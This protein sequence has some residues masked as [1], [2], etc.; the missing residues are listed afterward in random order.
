VTAPNAGAPTAARG[1][2]RTGVDLL[3]YADRLGGTVADLAALLAGPLDAFTGVH[4]LP[5]FVPYDGADAGFD[6]VDH[7]T[8]DPRLGTWD[9]VAALARHR[10]LTADLIVNHVSSG[11]EPFR[12]WVAHGDAS[13]H[14]GM[15]LTYGTVFPGGATEA[16][17]SAIYRPRPGLPFTPTMVGATRRLLW[18]TFDRTQIDLDVHHPA[19]RRH[20]REVLGLLAAAGARTVRLDAVGY[21]VKTAGTDCFLT[22]ETMA[23]VDDLTAEARSLGLEV[24]VELHGHHRLQQAVAPHVDHV[25]DFGLPPLVLHALLTGRTHGLARWFDVRPTNTVNVLDTHDGIG[26]I[27]V[28]AEGPHAGIL[29][30]EDLTELVAAVEANTR[31]VSA[32]AS[33]PVPWAPYPYQL[34][35]TYYDALDRD[36]DRYVAARAIQLLTPG[37]P[38]VYYAGLLA[39]GNDTE[40]LARTGVGREVNRPVV[41][42]GDLGRHLDRPV[43]RALLALVRLRGAHPAFGGGQTTA[44]TADEVALTWRSG[45]H[46]AGVRIAPAEGTFELRWTTAAGVRRA[47]DTDSLA[48]AV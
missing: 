28:A 22:P 39:L 44:I 10:D 34:N 41:A 38:Q 29:A 9:D 2:R 12:D 32:R 43:V 33:R 45:P 21:A 46:E 25:Y 19:A 1:P 20:L 11:S 17:L 5:F 27:D 23:F 40:R 6:P 30:D 48:D 7:T 16:D 13:A 47:V 3:A 37:I 18:T 8:V 24:L 26:I 36:D 15:F 31:G 14:A 4:L 35:T 42:P